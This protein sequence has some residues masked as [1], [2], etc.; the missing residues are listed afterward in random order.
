MVE[1]NPGKDF[2]LGVDVLRN[3]WFLQKQGKFIPTARTVFPQLFSEPREL[4]GQT[5]PRFFQN[6]ETGIDLLRI[7][8]GK[9][10]GVI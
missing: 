9:T 2:H 1:G 6:D 8:H 5:R 10:G 3:K 4:L 7:S